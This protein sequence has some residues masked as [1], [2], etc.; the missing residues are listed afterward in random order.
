MTQN[1]RNS[2]KHNSYLELTG[3]KAETIDYGAKL[4]YKE[5]NAPDKAHQYTYTKSNVRTQI[6]IRSFHL[7]FACIIAGFQLHSNKISDSIIFAH[8]LLTGLATIQNTEA[9]QNLC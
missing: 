1:T 7:D 8:D 2:N 3:V 9:N 4:P 5:L 6:S